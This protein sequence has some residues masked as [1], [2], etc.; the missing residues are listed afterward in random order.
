MREILADAPPKREGLG[1][2]RAGIRAPGLEGDLRVDAAEQP[3]QGAERIRSGRVGEPGREVLQGPVRRREIRLAEVEEVRQAL[4][5]AGQDPGRVLRLD[6]AL[7][8][9]GQEFHGLVGLEGVAA[10]AVAVLEGLQLALDIRL[11]P[12]GADMLAVVVA[13]R[14]PQD[15][16][17]RPGGLVVLVARRVLDADPHGVS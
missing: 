10:V 2:R 16:Q 7:D 11:D 4:D 5:R 17:Y 8:Q 9:E 14:E 3:V 6:L 15:L 12:P 1:G 13:G